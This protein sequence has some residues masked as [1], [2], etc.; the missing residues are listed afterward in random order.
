MPQLFPG[1]TEQQNYLRFLIQA[2]AIKAAASAAAAAAGVSDP[3]MAQQCGELL[4]PASL[5]PASIGAVLASSSLADCLWCLPLI[6]VASCCRFCRSCRLPSDA[7][8]G[9]GADTQHHS[10]S[11]SPAPGAVHS[12]R[13]VRHVACVVGS[14]LAILQFLQRGLVL[15]VLPAAHNHHKQLDTSSPQGWHECVCR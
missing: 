14:K 7:Q 11:S 4:R 3:D 13:C 9:G 15:H 2:A 12:N 10:S 6:C 1:D 5:L 8:P